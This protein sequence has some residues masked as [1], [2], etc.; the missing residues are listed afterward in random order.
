MVKRLSVLDANR[1]TGCQ[2]CMFAC[3]RRFGVGGLAHSAIHVRSVGGI[4]HG[5]VVIVCR[6]CPNPPCA[7]VC[8]VGALKVR[9]GGGVIL[10]ATKC[11]GCGFCAKSCPYGAIFWNE[12]ENKP[13]VCVYCGYCARYC[14]HDVI[15]LEEVGEK[16]WTST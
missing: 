16:I 8:P 9:E 13:N 12:K 15:A 2:S 10:D 11:I 14:P 4:E 1:C 6:A 3:S 7:K 5:F